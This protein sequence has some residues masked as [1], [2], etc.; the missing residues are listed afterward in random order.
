MDLKAYREEQIQIIQEIEKDLEAIR[1]SHIWQRR[2]DLTD[3]DITPRHI[4]RLERYLEL[5]KRA[6]EVTDANIAKDGG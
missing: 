5:M 6:V 4:E 3:E 2:P 1:K